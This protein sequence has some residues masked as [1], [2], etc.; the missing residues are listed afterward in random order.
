MGCALA[1]DRINGGQA[2][3]RQAFA[4]T[5]VHVAAGVWIGDERGLEE[6]SRNP[7]APWARKRSTHLATVFSVVLNWRAAG[8]LAHPFVHHGTHHGLSTF[9]GQTRILVGVHSVLC[10]SLL[11]GDISVPGQDRMDNLLKVHI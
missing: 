10:E 7:S 1:A 2:H 3:E 4:S 11:F 8:G 5:T 6:R 9:W